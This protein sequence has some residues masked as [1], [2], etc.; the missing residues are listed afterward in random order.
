[1]EHNF[2]NKYFDLNLKLTINFFLKFYVHINHVILTHKHE[3][4]INIFS[5][6]LIKKMFIEK[7]KSQNFLIIIT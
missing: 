5:T 3:L 1:M 6:K 2:S 4:L 7:Q